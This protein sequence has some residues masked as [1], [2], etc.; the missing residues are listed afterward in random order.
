MQVCLEFPKLALQRLQTLA[1]QHFVD[2]DRL[3]L[4]DL[5]VHD[6]RR[7]VGS[8][9]ASSGASLPLIGKVLNHKTHQATQVYARFMLDPVRDALEQVAAQVQGTRANRS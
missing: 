9:L 8:W 2:A 1:N 7:T 5:R 3:S 4:L 6:L